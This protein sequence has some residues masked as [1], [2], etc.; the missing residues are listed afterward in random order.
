MKCVLADRRALEK[1]S[2]YCWWICLPGVYLR[3]FSV[4]L[5]DRPRRSIFRLGVW[6]IHVDIGPEWV[7]YFLAWA[8]VRSW[9][10][11]CLPFSCWL[12]TRIVR[13]QA[14]SQ[15]P[16]GFVPSPLLSLRHSLLARAPARLG[17]LTHAPEKF[18]QNKMY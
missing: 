3:T 5:C 4:G 14:L 13:H 7:F 15:R 12:L 9:L 1:P 8:V 11:G 6:G 2:L 17:W 10:S 18:A 16:L